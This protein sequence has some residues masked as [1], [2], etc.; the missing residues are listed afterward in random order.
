MVLRSLSIGLNR[1]L[2]DVM[3][4][5]M[6]ARLPPHGPVGGGDRAKS[7]DFLGIAHIGGK[8][9]VGSG[10]SPLICLP[11]RNGPLLMMLPQDGRTIGSESRHQARS[12]DDG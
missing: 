7:L 5:F 8:R 1:V 4:A 11:R 3:S 2:A 6:G 9:G 12:V 10:G